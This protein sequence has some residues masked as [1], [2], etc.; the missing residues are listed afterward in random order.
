MLPSIGSCVGPSIPCRI[1]QVSR[2]PQPSLSCTSAIVWTEIRGS[3]TAHAQW[4]KWG[5]ERT[6][7][8]LEE[9]TM[10]TRNPQYMV[11]LDVGSTTVKAVVTEPGK[12]PHPVAG[13]P[14]S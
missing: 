4:F 6:L 3:G 8:L 10:T 1:D 12:R 9:S 11:G 2:A 13:L 5:P 14:A 7:A